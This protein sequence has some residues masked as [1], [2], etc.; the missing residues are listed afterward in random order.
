MFKIGEFIPLRVKNCTLQLWEIRN[1]DNQTTDYVFKLH[2]LDDNFLVDV[3][4]EYFKSGSEEVGVGFL[5]FVKASN[6]DREVVNIHGFRAITMFKCFLDLI[7]YVENIDPRVKYLAFSM[8]KREA[9]RIRAHRAII[10]RYA[11]F[12]PSAI[13]DIVKNIYPDGLDSSILFV[14]Q[15]AEPGTDIKKENINLELQALGIDLSKL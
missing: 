4:I 3:R 11:K 12:A 6:F 8:Y 13:Y 9:S 14:I 5:G 1:N 2:A 7:Q 10:K 15:R